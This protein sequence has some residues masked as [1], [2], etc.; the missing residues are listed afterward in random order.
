[1]VSIN[2]G[3]PGTERICFQAEISGRMR[4]RRGAFRG[5][6]L[7]HNAPSASLAA[8]WSARWWPCR[9]QPL[10]SEALESARPNWVAMVAFAVAER[11]NGHLL[12]VR[13]PQNAVCRPGQLSS[14][15]TAIYAPW[16]RWARPAPVREHG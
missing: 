9:R 8:L 12:E 10:L 15:A 3:F 7:R 14:G 2:L 13:E 6:L 5:T 4:L 1:V 16:I 11:A